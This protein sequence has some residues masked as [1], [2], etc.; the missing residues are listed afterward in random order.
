MVPSSDFDLTKSGR[1]TLKN[2]ACDVILHFFFLP[3]FNSVL[4]KLQFIAL[5][6]S[7]ITRHETREDEE[8]S[9][10]KPK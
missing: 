9:K 10:I 4:L 8:T 1:K 5:T 3:V 6:Q 2:S 7:T